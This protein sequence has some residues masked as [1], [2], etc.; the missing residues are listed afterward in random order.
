MLILFKLT[1]KDVLIME[2]YKITNKVEIS[3]VFFFY[4]EENYYEYIYL[5]NPYYCITFNVM[6][7]THNHMHTYILHT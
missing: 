7:Y 5:C 2:K 3:F 1:L 4:P 6:F